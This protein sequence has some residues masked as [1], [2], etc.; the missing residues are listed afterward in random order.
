MKYSFAILDPCSHCYLHPDATDG[1]CKNNSSGYC[2][3][4]ANTHTCSVTSGRFT[5]FC[6]PA[7]NFEAT[8]LGNLSIKFSIRLYLKSALF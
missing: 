6:R 3:N 8:I 7:G 5:D 2:V 1:P 4:Q